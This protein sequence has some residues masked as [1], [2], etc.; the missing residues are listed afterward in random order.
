[1]SFHNYLLSSCLLLLVYSA[2]ATIF[3]AKNETELA[4]ANKNAKPGDVVVLKDG[5]WNNTSIELTAIGK[6]KYPITFKAESPGG[7]IITGNSRLKIGGSYIIVE[8]LYFKDGFSG[9]DAVISFRT[10][11][12][13][14]ASNCRVT[15][16]T[17]NN[18]NNPKRLEEN[19][20]VSFYGKQNRIDHCSF[21]NKKNLGVLMAVILE[22]QRSRENFHSIDHNYFGFRIP[23]ASNAGEIIRIGVAEH[24]EFNSNT[25]ITNNFFENCDGET[26]I[27]SIKSGS[28]LIQN[29]LFKECQGAVVLRHGN[30]N[31]IENNIF[32]GNDKKGSGGVRVINKGQWVVN[33]F[34]YRCK[35]VGFRS[36]LSV[37]NGVPNS[38]A[39]RYVSVSDAVIAN[40]SFVEC[41]PFSLSE[42]SDSERSETPYNVQFVN[43]LFFSNQN[44]ILYKVYDNISGIQF[45]GNTIS[46]TYKQQTVAGFEKPSFITTCQDPFQSLNRTTNPLFQ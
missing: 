16:T 17:I 38:P 8:G 30:F 4:T 20:W 19:Y 34:F 28:N 26:E 46:N 41:A 45:S 32:L 31:T 35:G 24:C 7:V 22:D 21:Q 44:N 15:N 25:Q 13:Q 39:L 42:G 1:M 14:I 37:M 27:I 18:F 5:I 2:N 6:R 9:T 12:N 29:N 11:K 23:L 3:I 33:N 43:N 36:P 10:S 40:N